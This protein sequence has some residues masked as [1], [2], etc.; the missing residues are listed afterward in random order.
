MSIRLINSAKLATTSNS[1]IGVGQDKA[2]A[3]FFLRINGPL[4]LSS[5]GWLGTW[6]LSRSSTAGFGV[7]AY[8]IDATAQTMDLQLLWRASN[9]TALTFR[10]TIFPGV[11]YCIAMVYDK[12]DPSNQ[13]AYVNGVKFAMTP[14][15]TLNLST[16]STAL[17]VG[18]TFGGTIARDYSLENVM[19]W[20]GYVLTQSDVFSIMDRTG[21][22]ATIGSSA[23]WRGIWPL[24]GEVGTIPASGDGGLNNS[25][26][27]SWPFVPSVNSSVA[28]SSI[29]YG[30]AMPFVSQAVYGS[31]V[32]ASGGKTIRVLTKSLTGVPVKVVSVSSTTPTIKING[33]SPISLTTWFSENHSGVLYFLPSG[34]SV[35]PG[36]SVTFTAPEGFLATTLGTVA[37]A[38]DLPC[39]NKSGVPI[40]GDQ[41]RTLFAGFNY[42]YSASTNYSWYQGPSNWA[43]RLNIDLANEAPGNLREDHTLAVNRNGV[44]LVNTT[45]PNGV[46]LL[47]YPMPTGKWVISYIPRDAG[48]E[49]DIW[50]DSVMPLACNEIRDYRNEGS[51]PGD[52]VIK[53]FDVS[54]SVPYTS[55]LNGG[56]NASTTTVTLTNTTNI[57]GAGFTGNPIMWLKVDDEYM[58]IMAVNHST[59]TL[60][61]VRGALGS[62]ASSHANGT[63]CISQ[64]YAENPKLRVNFSGPSG[65]PHYSDLVIY[66]PADWTPPPSVEAVT[67]LDTSPGAQIRPSKFIRDSLPHCEIV[68]HMDSGGAFTQMAEPEHLRNV[69]DMY[70][71]QDAKFI[72]DF[73]ITDLKPF[74]PSVTPYVYWHYSG[75]PGAET[76]SAT[77]ASAID[78]SQT[79]ITISDAATAPVLIGSRLFI[80]SEQLRVTAVS[81]TSVS[82]VRGCMGT[83]AASHSSGSITVGWRVPITSTDQYERINSVAVDLTT[84]Q[85]HGLFSGMWANDP[86]K[87]D[88]NPLA[89]GTVTLAANAS[90]GS[91]S[92]TLSASDWTYIKTGMYIKFGSESVRLA[93]VNSGTGAVTLDYELKSSHTS[94]ETGT[95]MACGVWVKSTDG[96][97]QAWSPNQAVFIPFFVTGA[98]RLFARL[99]VN[100]GGAVGLVDGD[101]TWDQTPS[102]VGGTDQSQ[103]HWKLPISIYPMEYMAGVSALAPGCYHWLNIPMLASDD[104]VREMA[105]RTRDN[106]PSGV[107]HKIIV[108]LANEVWNDAFPFVNYL[109]ATGALWGSATNYIDAWVLRTKAV[110]DIVK[111]VFAA[112]SHDAQVLL[113][114][115]NQTGSIDRGL[116]RARA[117]GIDV[118]VCGTAPYFRPAT[119]ATS[120]A[121]FNTIDDEQGV[122][123]WL[124][125][126]EC[127]LTAGSGATVRADAKK[128]IEHRAA[129]SYP[130]QW[131]NYEGGLSSVIAVPPNG[132]ND[133]SVYANGYAR[134]LDMSYNPAMY[135]AHTDMLSIC[136]SLGVQGY[137][138]FNHCQM[139]SGVNAGTGSYQEMWGL[140]SYHGQPAGRGDGSDG[141]ADNRLCLATPGKPNTKGPLQNLAGTNVA[142]RLQSVLDWNEARTNPVVESDPLP[143]RIPI[144]FLRRRKARPASLYR[145]PM[146]HA[147]EPPAVVTRP[148]RLPTPVYFRKRGMAPSLARVPVEHVPPG[149]PTPDPVPVIGRRVVIHRLTIF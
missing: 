133:T 39:V 95:T 5:T 115:P 12:D 90:A 111:A 52:R 41:P 148:R 149:P 105:I 70:W 46:D 14:S 86:D 119:T 44:M 98:N 11:V 132:T 137:C 60:T 8:G 58:S 7:Q 6:L 128:L 146:E 9:G 125:D 93:T 50:L 15:Q 16:S 78:A 23:S 54:D 106:L 144:P 81:G 88:M 21:D 13:A 56:I 130:I 37:A 38:S 68:R 91:K 96:A 118:D 31:P 43:W 97:V 65:A 67:D 110:T 112:T 84:D 85:A 142:V 136:Q 82:V 45:Y 22:I 129:T 27:G 101:Q 120:M 80:G 66:C 75:V 62:T 94:G 59:K 20:N 107:G 141:K 1:V 126:F 131:I 100:L 79:T 108:E 103:L 109:Q 28:G 35:A 140:T 25:V 53:V 55:A 147:V 73:R 99:Y 121:L 102:V 143:R 17:E 48:R 135:C 122:D 92:M 42:T 124:F 33:G 72:R 57:Q 64:F 29:V 40:Y 76:Y 114:L 74:D 30:E 2:S 18:N 117:L 61:V 24:N 69:S 113:S 116:I 71:G 49:T 138:F 134:N 89:R 139:P 104:M 123:M 19:W 26:D 4:P 77:L 36:D 51:A 34:T 127:N 145:I 32:V 3:V 47:S 10:P 87:L 63:S 83:T